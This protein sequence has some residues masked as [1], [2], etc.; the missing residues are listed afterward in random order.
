MRRLLAIL[1]V[2]AGL[3]TP[4]SAD[5]VVSGRSAQALRCAAYIGMTASLGYDEGVLSAA[6]TGQLNSWSAVVL[7]RWVP[8]APEGQLAA[9]RTVLGEIGSRDRTYALFVRHADWCLREFTPRL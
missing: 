3:G 5:T 6:E 4:A 9:Y 8:L 2:A 7:Q 1:V